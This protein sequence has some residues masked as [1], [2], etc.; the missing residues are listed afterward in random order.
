MNGGAHLWA[1][2]MLALPGSALRG[3]AVV[4]GVG[5]ALADVERR[6]ARRAGGY[7]FRV[8]FPGGG[9]AVVVNGRGTSSPVAD[10]L[11][12]AWNS[13]TLIPAG[14]A[15][16]GTVARWYRVGAGVTCGHL[17]LNIAAYLRGLHAL[18]GVAL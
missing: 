13:G 2:P 17:P 10:V 4:A 1:F 7:A 14:V 3:P 15:G 11:L 9:F 6:G 16:A 12:P 5:A 18:R 8:V